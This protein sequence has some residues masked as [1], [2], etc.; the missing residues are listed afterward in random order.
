ML[1]LE[2]IDLCAPAAGDQEYPRKGDEDAGECRGPCSQPPQGFC[3]RSTLCY[4]Q[5]LHRDCIVITV[6]IAASL[7]C[8]CFSSALQCA[9]LDYCD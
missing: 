2:T 9:R 8:L 7:Y 6:Y 4:Q 5:P 1:P 3:M